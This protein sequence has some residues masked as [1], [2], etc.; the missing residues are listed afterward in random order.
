MNSTGI[1]FLG[2]EDVM[3]GQAPL[4][5]HFHYFFSTKDHKIVVSFIKVDFSNETIFAYSV[6]LSRDEID[7][8]RSKIYIIISY[9]IFYL[10]TIRLKTIP[11]T[12][13][14]YIRNETIR[15]KIC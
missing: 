5:D 9:H 3:E 6:V 13:N 1:V 8:K 4:S 11:I 12:K 14:R 2:R 15:S 7:R 10:E